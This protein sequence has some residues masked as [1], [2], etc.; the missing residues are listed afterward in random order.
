[1]AATSHVAVL[2]ILSCPTLNVRQSNHHAKTAHRSGHTGERSRL[3]GL[4]V[5]RKAYT[6]QSADRTPETGRHYHYQ[7]E[8]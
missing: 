2:L 4:F 8:N 5:N 3:V 1:V 7:P 6:R